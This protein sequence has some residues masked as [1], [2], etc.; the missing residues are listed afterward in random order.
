MKIL[1]RLACLLGLTSTLVFC[2][3]ISDLVVSDGL[4]ICLSCL[5]TSH[6]SPSTQPNL[7]RGTTSAVPAMRSRRIAEIGQ[8]THNSGQ[9][10]PFT[11]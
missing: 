6:R 7:S 4:P 1:L 9:P 2:W 8:P 5:E 11:A 10:Q 3:P